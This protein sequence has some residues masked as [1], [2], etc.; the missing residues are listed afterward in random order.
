MN[1]KELLERAV[2]DT[3][4][5]NFGEDSFREGLERLVDAAE[6]EANLSD[7]GRKAFHELVIGTLVN[8]LEVEDW[9]TRHPEIDEQ[10]I[11]QPLIG[12][13]LPRTGSTAFFNMLSMDPNIRTIR[14]WE[15]MKP[16]PP[17]VAGEEDSDPRVQAMAAE[18]EA[19]YRENPRLRTMLPST[20]VSAMECGILMKGEF[21]TTFFSSMQEIPS[22]A[23]WLVAEADVV[24]TYRY[25][26]RVL[27]LLQWRYPSRRWRLKSPPHSMF[28]RELNEVFPDARFWMTHRD[29]GK[30]I[31]SVADLFA[32]HR[33]RYTDHVDKHAIGRFNLD[34]WEEALKRMLAFRQEADND[35]RF[36]DVYFDEFQADPFPSIAGLYDFM[37]EKLTEQTKANIAA[38][39]E[40]SPKGKHGAHVYDAADYGVDLSDLYRR[41][42]FYSRQVKL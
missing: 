38:W 13:G 36:Y 37:G 39:R 31:P 27:K 2:R 22:Y 7:S 4:L 32:E 17:P 40:E 3:G 42:E 6:T 16:C 34:F 29:I 30:V 18:M 23:A 8:R 9:Y 14:N 1:V 5:D 20:A 41:F 25:L 15:A 12:L 35:A 21:K 26:K 24:S 33:K 19:R 10:E 11:E 28:I